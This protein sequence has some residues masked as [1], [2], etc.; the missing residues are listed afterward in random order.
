MSYVNK[1][2][3]KSTGVKSPGKMMGKIGK[4]IP[5]RQDRQ[6]KASREN[7]GKKQGNQAYK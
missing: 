5:L 6:N 4:Q 7:K 3:S 1:S 2:R